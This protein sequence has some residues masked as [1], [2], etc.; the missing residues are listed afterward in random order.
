[1]RRVA[2]SATLHFHRRMFED[3]RAA[4]LGMT[5]DADP[6][7]GLPQHG[8]IVGPVWVVA[9][10]ALHESFGNAGMGW[11]SE[12]RVNGGMARIT[13]QRRRL[14]QQALCHPAFLFAET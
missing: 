14:R 1:M 12:L 10:C 3:E 8:L 6:P 4:F 9:V 7:V 2:C 11:Q 13:R 5:I